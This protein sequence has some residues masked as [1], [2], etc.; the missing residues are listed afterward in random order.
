MLFWRALL[1]DPQALALEARSFHAPEDDQA[2]F[3]LREALPNLP[4]EEQPAAFFILNR[5]AFSGIMFGGRT[6]LRQQ[7]VGRRVQ[8][9]IERL[10]DFRAPLLSVAHAPFQESLPR[11][12]D[13]FLYLD[14]PYYAARGLYAVG[15]N[16]SFDHAGL[17][18]LLRAREGWL[19][20]YDDCE[21]VRNAY[22]GCRFDTPRW[23]YNLNRS[24][25]SGELLIRP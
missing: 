24:K 16:G 15:G 17:A 25:E 14:P 1:D 22:A 12:A 10:L 21:W 4:D 13:D 18:A 9:A 2:Y 3:N 5:L 11:H 7:G 6:R 19:L 8:A 20:S 23:A